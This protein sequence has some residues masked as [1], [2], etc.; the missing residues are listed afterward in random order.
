[1][2]DRIADIEWIEPGELT[3]A[4]PGHAVSLLSPDDEADVRRQPSE[5]TLA[6]ARWRGR[7]RVRYRGWYQLS[8]GAPSPRVDSV[9]RRV[10]RCDVDEALRLIQR[11]TEFAAALE[12][13]SPLRPDP[14]VLQLRAPGRL[15]VPLSRPRLPVWLAVEPWWRDQS[16]VTMWLRSTHRW[17]Y[18]S[19]YFLTAHRAMDQL[20][21]PDR[22]G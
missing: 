8:A 3:R 4:H 1:M 5:L 12:L 9:V 22:I 20:T 7:W 18:P 16:L 15:R 2:A 14:L 17:R 19:R 6:A 11:Q 13:D 21:R 10:L